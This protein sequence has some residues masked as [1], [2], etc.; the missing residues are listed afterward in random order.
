[1]AETQVDWILAD[2]SDYQPERGAYDLALISY[3]QAGHEVRAAALA[4]AAAALAPG[5]TVFVVGF[6]VVNLTEGTGRPRDPDVLYTPEAVCA[7]LPGLR[8][9]RAERVHRV[10]QTET[11]A[12]PVTAVDTVVRAVR[13][14]R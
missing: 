4:A 14:E 9:V 13:L 5:G 2:L 6:D 3:L 10:V 8:I 1:M 11:E 12:G 7:E